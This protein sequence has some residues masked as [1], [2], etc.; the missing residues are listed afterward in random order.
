MNKQKKYIFIQELSL[1]KRNNLMTF[2][3]KQTTIQNS[4]AKMNTLQ[5]KNDLDTYEKAQANP[6]K[7]S[8]LSIHHRL[9]FQLLKII[10]HGRN[11][12]L[13]KKEYKK[14]SMRNKK[15]LLLFILYQ[16]MFF[17]QYSTQPKRLI[18]SVL[19]DCFP[20]RYPFKFASVTKHRINTDFI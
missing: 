13:Y 17:Q 2:L 9:I 3:H 7:L 20:Q 18:H 4:V 11:T 19:E 10:P 1:T 14:E 16:I 15:P 12:E 8:M 6:S 5:N